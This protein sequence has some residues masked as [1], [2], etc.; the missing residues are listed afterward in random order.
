MELILTDQQKADQIVLTAEGTAR[1]QRRRL[2]TLGHPA[3]DKVNPN[4]KEQFLRTVAWLEDQKIRSLE[5]DSRADLREATSPDWPAALA[6]YLTSL[7]CPLPA[8]VA[9]SPLLS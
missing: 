5:S 3:P 6:T 4:D 7:A 8:G 1:Y 2:A 9:P